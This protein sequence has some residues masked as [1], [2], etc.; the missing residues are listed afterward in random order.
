MPFELLFDRVPRMPL[1]NSL[2]GP[3]DR[4]QSFVE[5]QSLVEE[6]RKEVY[7]RF[8]SKQSKTKALVDLRRRVSC[9]HFN[10]E[11]LFWCVERRKRRERPGNL[12]GLFK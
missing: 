1:E 5:F 12:L 8:I 7:M 9:S 3:A 11:S 10:P 2:S 4:P 6:L